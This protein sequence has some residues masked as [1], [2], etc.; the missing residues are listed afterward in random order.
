MPRHFSLC[1]FVTVMFRS[2]SIRLFML[3]LLTAA[4]LLA[5]A[6]AAEHGVGEHEHEGV[7]CVYGTANDENNGVIPSSMA[8][9]IVA[10]SV[11]SL[12]PFLDHSKPTSDSFLPPATGPP[13]SS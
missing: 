12:V 5:I 6:H 3:A 8:A 7:Q 11:H 1:Y 13:P 4:Q 10:E 2:N 9:A